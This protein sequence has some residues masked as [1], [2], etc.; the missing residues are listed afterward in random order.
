MEK[1]I[2]SGLNSETYE[3]EHNL[4]E[5]I[6]RELSGLDMPCTCKSELDRTIV[7]IEA[8]RQRKARKELV[9]SIRE[10]YHNLVSGISFL[11]ELENIDRLELTPEELYDHAESLKFLADLAD[12]CADRLVGLSTISKI[13]K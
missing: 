5:Q 4:I 1:D 9:D 2:S 11:T 10:D 13:M 8:W 3:K 12:R 7:A 6:H